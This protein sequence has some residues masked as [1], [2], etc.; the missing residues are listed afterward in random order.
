MSAPERATI[1][2]VL[3]SGLKG[4]TGLCGGLCSERWPPQTEEIGDQDFASRFSAF[5]NHF[6]LTDVEQVPTMPCEVKPV[7]DS[8]W[9]PVHL[10]EVVP[11]FAELQRDALRPIRGNCTLILQSAGKAKRCKETASITTNVQPPSTTG[12]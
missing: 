7:Y 5:R 4:S 2:V 3:C 11:C 9:E 6:P 1:G 10:R 12:L 8:S